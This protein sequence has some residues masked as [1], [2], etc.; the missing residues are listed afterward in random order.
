MCPFI[1]LEGIDGV[2]KTTCAQLLAQEL[3]GHYMATPP[4]PFARIRLEIDQ[5]DDLA[6]RF[7]Y[8]VSAIVGTSAVIKRMLNSYPVVCDRYIYS[9][10]AYHRALGVATDSLIVGKLPI[11][12]PD[13]S[14][15]LTATEQARSKRL[16][17]R[18]MGN[19]DKFF[20]HDGSRREELERQ[21]NTF[22]LTV[23]D[24]TTLTPPQVVQ[25]LL[26]IVRGKSS[27]ACQ[28]AQEAES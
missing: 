11:T 22:N 15:F 17:Q 21:F 4:H 6:S 26:N 27:K 18:G 8:Y 24:T 5:M 23:V 16:K 7:F 25:N 28:K 13:H 14:F 9:T 20:Q 10:L 12:W 2:G 1:V 19:W 3:N